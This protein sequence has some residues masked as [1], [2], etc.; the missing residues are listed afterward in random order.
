MS[1]A[2]FGNKTGMKRKVGALVLAA[3]VLCISSVSQPTSA[4][5][6]SGLGAPVE[7]TW[8]NTITRINQGGAT[9]TAVVSFAGGGVWQATGST[10]R[11]NGGVSTLVGSWKRIGYNLYSS[12][13]YFY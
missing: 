12:R 2:S 3:S 10:E 7:G 6:G 4:Q 5:S 13:A 11:Q 8:L 1:I 9:F